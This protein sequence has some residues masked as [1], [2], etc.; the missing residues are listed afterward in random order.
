MD[1]GSKQNLCL[2]SEMDLEIGGSSSSNGGLFSPSTLQPSPFASRTQSYAQTSIGQHP[3]EALG[4]LL[5]DHLREAFRLYKRDGEA[6]GT[7]LEGL[8]LPLG[9]KGAGTARLGGRRLFM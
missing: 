4:P 7:G 5:P 2:P 3:K 1:E 6:G 9:V 8:S